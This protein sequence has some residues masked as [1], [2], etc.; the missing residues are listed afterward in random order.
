V[1]YKLTVVRVFVTD[2]KRALRFDSDRN[3]STLVGSA[4]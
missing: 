3:V 4:P 1:E 2:W